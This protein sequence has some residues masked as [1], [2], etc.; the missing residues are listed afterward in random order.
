MRLVGEVGDELLEVS[1]DAADGGVLR[2][3]LAFDARHLVGEAGRERLNRLV[4]RFLPEPLVAAEH[5]FDRREQR[6]FEGRG[7]VQMVANPRLQFTACLRLRRFA[8]QLVGPHRAT[9]STKGVP[10][11]ERAFRS[12][13]Y[14]GVRELYR[15]RRT[16]PLCGNRAAR[17]AAMRRA[18]AVSL[19]SYE[20]L[21]EIIFID[22]TSSLRVA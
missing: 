16:L 18:R 4:F 20:Q 21:E 19:C 15:R 11:G 7:E 14:G 9:T 17:A 2:E 8:R 12:I 5:R 1:R 6:L 22:F 3:Q 13:F 10:D